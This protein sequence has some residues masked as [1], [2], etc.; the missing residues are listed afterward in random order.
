MLGN[1]H[2]CDHLFFH[3]IESFLNVFL[4]ELRPNHVGSATFLAC[5]LGELVSSMHSVG[6]REICTRHVHSIIQTHLLVARRY[7]RTFL[8]MFLDG[9]CG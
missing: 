8:G 5:P 3:T 4:S 2:S 1:V 7:C 9:Y 6:A